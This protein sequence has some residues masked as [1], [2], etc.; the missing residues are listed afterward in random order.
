MDTVNK[1]MAFSNDKTVLCAVNG[2]GSNQGVFDKTLRSTD[3]GFAVNI[4]KL[5]NKCR[6]TVR[7]RSKN[8]LALPVTD[9]QL[10]VN[11]DDVDN[12][13]KA[14]RYMQEYANNSAWKS[15][16][17]TFIRQ[18]EC[19]S[20]CKT[21]TF[22]TDDYW[23]CMIRHYARKASH[24]VSTCRMGALH[25]KTAVVDQYL[26]VKG[27]KNLRVADSS[28]MRNVP[29]GNKNAPT[30]M[31]REKAADRIKMSRHIGL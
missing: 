26:R 6:G 9:P 28:V 12:Y 2:L 5:H 18:G 25:D 11:Q 14:I 31:I 19:T 4:C 3:V 15:V 13:V 1:H 7:L 30:M 16:G 29:S 27:I 10:L 17:A 24:Q 8:Q 20:F 21:F 22:E 23:K